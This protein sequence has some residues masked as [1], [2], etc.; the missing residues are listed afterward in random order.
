MSTHLQKNNQ[1][2]KPNLLVNP[3]NILRLKMEIN[4]LHSDGRNERR[5]VCYGKA[6]Q[7]AI[8]NLVVEAVDALS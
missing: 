7:T 5:G 1:K 6:E 8:C 4:A 3:D 2:K